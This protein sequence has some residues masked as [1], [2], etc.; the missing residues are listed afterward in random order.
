MRKD[1]LRDSDRSRCVFTSVGSCHGRLHTDATTFRRDGGGGELYIEGVEDVEVEVEERPR[2]E[3]EFA[4][5]V[6][7]EEVVREVRAVERDAELSKVEIGSRGR[8][9]SIGRGRF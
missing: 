9:E 2:E 1:P 5:I 8:D 4:I 6:V 7:R 3:V